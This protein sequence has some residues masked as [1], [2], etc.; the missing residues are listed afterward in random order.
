MII[1]YFKTE[2]DL[3]HCSGKHGCVTWHVFLLLVVYEFLVLLEVHVL[4]S[5]SRPR[6]LLL[7]TIKTRKSV[8]PQIFS[9]TVQAC[10]VV[11]SW[12]RGSHKCSTL[13]KEPS[14][15]LLSFIC[16]HLIYTEFLTGPVSAR[17]SEEH[18]GVWFLFSLIISLKI[19]EEFQSEN[20]NKR[21]L[22][23]TKCL[24]LCL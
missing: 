19:P 17:S 3:N 2:S 10:K 22:I 16:I 15:H 24:A 1:Y 13:N 9:P 8:A 14:R 18:K 11:T 4:L 20:L 23:K 7:R 6:V 21:P 5:C 12:W